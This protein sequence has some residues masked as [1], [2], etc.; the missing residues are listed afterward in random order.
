MAAKGKG[1]NKTSATEDTSDNSIFKVL[2][3]YM[4]EYEK[5]KK[6]A[7]ET[8]NLIDSITRPFFDVYKEYKD[9]Q[10]EKEEEHL[11]AKRE[12]ETKRKIIFI[13]SNLSDLKGL[14]K[15]NINLC[16]VKSFLRRSRIIKPGQEDDVYE[17]ILNGGE[18]FWKYVLYNIRVSINKELTNWHNH[19]PLYFESSPLSDKHRE[20]RVIMPSYESFSS[21]R[22]ILENRESVIISD[23]L[24]ENDCKNLYKNFMYSALFQVI[25]VAFH[26]VDHVHNMGGDFPVDL[27]TVVGVRNLFDDSYGTDVSCPAIIVTISKEE[28]SKLN[29]YRMNPESVLNRLEA[30]IH[31]NIFYTDV[32]EA[33]SIKREEDA[34]KKTQKYS[35]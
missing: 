34:K 5:S 4:K 21:A 35:K 2:N 22:L 3:S 18:W 26:C 32:Y 19:I 20:I 17:E 15:K 10:A 9:A 11:K 13:A 30:E 14:H 25:A 24:E 12:E 23:Y 8:I 33:E 1:T 7:E 27:L 28:Y 16:D 6:E 31:E 29:R